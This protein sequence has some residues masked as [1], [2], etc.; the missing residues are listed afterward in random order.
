M[1]YRRV[2]LEG[3]LQFSFVQCP[4]LTQACTK[5]FLTAFTVLIR[6]VLEF[7]RIGLPSSSR[8]RLVLSVFQTNAVTYSSNTPF[9]SF[10]NKQSLNSQNNLNVTILC[11]V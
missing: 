11:S 7:F 3:H 9:A 8:P 6:S 4:Q 10:R 1:Y 5:T 2:N